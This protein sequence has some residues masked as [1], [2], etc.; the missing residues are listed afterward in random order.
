MTQGEFAT[1]E[2]LALHEGGWSSCSARHPDKP[3]FTSKRALRTS[4]KYAARSVSLLALKPVLSS[5]H[6]SHPDLGGGA[7]AALAVGGEGFTNPTQ[8][9]E[10]SK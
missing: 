7:D 5:R 6:T 1:G 10:V 3:R 4:N 9:E 8:T 2:R